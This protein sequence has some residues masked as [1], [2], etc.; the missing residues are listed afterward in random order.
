[1]KRNSK[2]P[3]VSAAGTCLLAGLLTVGLAGCAGYRL[4]STL[5][6]DIHSVA[7]PIFVNQTGRPNLESE[8]TKATLEEFQKD[9][10]L[11]IAS[12][13][14]ADTI[15]EV[16]LTQYSL[17]PISYRSSQRTTP[18]EYRLRLTASM[19]FRKRVSREV[20]AEY[21]NVYGEKVFSAPGDLQS[22]ERSALPDAASDLAHRI[23]RNVVES[24]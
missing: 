1:M 5:P 7:V 12:V 20:L 15:V 22:R 6:R 16:T 2:L 24:W 4:G 10:G 3:F 18:L 23:V 14:Q 11:K 19:V 17:T 13:D 9:G 8:A 21:R